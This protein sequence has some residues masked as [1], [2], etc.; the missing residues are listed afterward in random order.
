MSQ[1]SN[2]PPMY[3]ANGSTVA[4][5]PSPTPSA[6]EQQDFGGSAAGRAILNSQYPGYPGQQQN[7]VASNYTGAA[8]AQ[9]NQSQQNTQSQTQANR[10][11]QNTAFGYSNWYQGPDGQWHQQTGFNGALGGAAQGLEAQLAANAGH[12]FDNGSAARDQAIQSA[13]TQSTS[14]LD[15]RFNQAQEQLQAQ[16]AN[17]GLDPN[18]AAYR[19]AMQQFSQQRND[20][21]Q[22]AMNSAIGQGT[23]A[24][25]ATF[26]E[27][28]QAQMAPFQQ[29]EALNGLGGMPSFMGANR[30]DPAQ[31][32]A[33]MTA[34]GNFSLGQADQNNQLLGSGLGAAGTAIG[35][36][37][38]LALS[39]ERMKENVVRHPF[40]VVPGV[41]LASFEYRHA[42][43]Q[44]FAGVIAQDL[45]RVAPQHVHHTEDGLKMVDPQFAPFSIK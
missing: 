31:L 41:P 5:S 6:Q 33:A 16:L 21:Y 37:A 38:G 28:L 7:A 30:A 26:G 34:Y 27:N 8:Q 43:G 42:P 14:R 22:G 24:Q 18:S 9:A 29:L 25:Q 2:P 3:N 13:Y 45:E 40:E 1:G 11:D 15:P 39:D 44:R 36:G 35:A 10:P 4:Q 17:E 12:P 19:N 20:A 23:A 32:L